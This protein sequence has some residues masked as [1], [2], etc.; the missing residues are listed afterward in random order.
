MPR[1]TYTTSDPFS[2]NVSIRPVLLAVG[3]QREHYLRKAANYARR[4]YR[5][6]RETYPYR[7]SHWS[8]ALRDA[9]LCVEQMYLDLGTFGVETIDKGH[10]RRSP[11]ITYLNAGDSYRLTILVINGRFRVGCPG[12]I[13]ELGDYD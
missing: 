2:V 13:V 9:M 12:D 7:S 5:K 8:F 4:M 10:N 6:L 11:A 1:Q 3:E